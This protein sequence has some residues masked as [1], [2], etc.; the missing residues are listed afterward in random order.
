MDE[1]KATIRVE[2][3][4]IGK[5]KAMGDPWHVTL[6]PAFFQATATSEP[7]L[8]LRDLLEYIVRAEVD[9]FRQRQEERRLL[10]VLS[11][12]EINAA[13]STGKISMGGDLEQAGAEVDEVEAV[14]VALQAFED[15]IY[16]AFIDGQPQRNLADPVQLQPASTLLF[17]RLVA[18]VGG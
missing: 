5:R 4:M 10:R 15:G 8:R 12:Q 6:P 7:G 11:P 14:R 1:A 17:I 13:A 3:R 18:L 9:A 2:A 16:L